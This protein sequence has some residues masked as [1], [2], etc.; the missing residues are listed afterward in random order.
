[1]DDKKERRCGQDYVINAS[2]WFGVP[3]SQEILY[4]MYC[5]KKKVDKRFIKIIE[6][7]LL[8][9]NSSLRISDLKY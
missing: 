6:S 8:I 2:M 1:M 9:L 7:P 5:P 4:N 3:T